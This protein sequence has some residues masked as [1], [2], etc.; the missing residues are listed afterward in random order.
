[1]RFAGVLLICF[2]LACG[3]FSLLAFGIGLTGK[4]NFIHTLFLGAMPLALVCSIAGV[5]LL[6]YGKSET[7]RD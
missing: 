5:L 1:M 2:A 3:C 4:E 7:N 6:I